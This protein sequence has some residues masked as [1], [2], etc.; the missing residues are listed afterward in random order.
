MALNE[1]QAA[2]VDAVMSW[3]TDKEA[4]PFFLLGGSAGTGQRPFRA[5]YRTVGPDAVARARGTDAIGR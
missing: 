3:L 4:D 5:S 1:Q 2:A